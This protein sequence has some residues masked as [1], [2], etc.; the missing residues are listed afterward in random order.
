MFVT[1]IVFSQVNTTS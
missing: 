1:K